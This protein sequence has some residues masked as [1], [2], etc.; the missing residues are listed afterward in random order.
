MFCN[1][2]DQIKLEN[3]AKVVY[4]MTCPGYFSKYVGKTNRNLIT[5]L[6]EHD[7]KP[8]LPMHQHLSNCDKFNRSIKLFE[9]PDV[10]SIFSKQL[11]L[12]NAIV[13]NVE[14]LDYNNKYG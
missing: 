12:H 7:I 10:N 1:T 9:L 4:G 6:D 5:T 14:I 2:K 3:K 13:D 11:H 8:E